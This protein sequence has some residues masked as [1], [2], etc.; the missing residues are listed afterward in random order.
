MLI[1]RDYQL[2]V[3]NKIVLALKQGYK[4]ILVVVPTGGGKTAIAT[5]LTRRCVGKGNS[6]FFICHRR[7]LI[8][9]TEKTYLKNDIS[10][11][12]I[13]G[14]READTKNNVQVA[15]INTLI[16]RMENYDKPRVCIWDECHHIAAGQW[17]KVF[18][19]YDS[20]VHVGLTATP[21]RLDGKTLAEYFDVLIEGPK[22][23]WLI[24]N[25]HLVKF[26]YYAPSDI[27]TSE[28]K[29]SNGEYTQSSLRNASFGTK[30]IGDNIKHYKELAY[31]KRN[32]VFA[33]N[34]K[35]SKEI[36]QRY[37]EAGI[38]AVHLDGDTDI[39]I[40]EQAIK[41]FEDGKVW[42]LSN[43]DLFGE[44]FD[45][46]AMEVVSLLRPTMSLAKFLQWC[47][48]VLRTC[49]E[50]NKEYAIILDHANNYKEHG[51]PNDNREWELKPSKNKRQKAKDTLSIK[52]CPECFFTHIVSLKCPECGHVYSSDG[53]TIKEIAGDLVIVGS[54]EHIEKRQKEFRE[55]DTFHKFA[56]TEVCKDL[57]MHKVVGMWKQRSGEDLKGSEFGLQVI[58]R[59]YGY[60]TG[61]AWRQWKMRSRK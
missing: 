51:F 49:F 1:L 32:V 14:G 61:W 43:V 50:I 8:N 13:Q 25:G 35:H 11:G 17:D 24:D 46:P 54:S 30:I 20:S 10:P 44:G 60:K 41:D 52:R 2:E 48:R 40:R 39:A 27:D 57:P 3:V 29:K 23:Q 37:I 36:V 53:V 55:A 6:L 45:L 15:S 42:V 59:V 5:E 34:V 9:Q 56:H 4:R 26:R 7:E 33:M 31:G 28:L 18:S 38:P 21:L 12:F 58:E 47:G 16:N 22:I 19:H